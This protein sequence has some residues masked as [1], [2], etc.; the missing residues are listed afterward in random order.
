[1]NET[2][3]KILRE[4]LIFIHKNEGNRFNGR[5]LSSLEEE[6]LRKHVGGS[7]FLFYII[8]LT[9]GAFIGFYS[10]SHVLAKRYT[11]AF[12]TVSADFQ[13]SYR[14]LQQNYADTLAKIE[15]QLDEAKR[16]GFKCDD[17]NSFMKKKL[18]TITKTDQNFDSIN[19][20]YLQTL[21]EKND[22]DEQLDVAI[23]DLKFNEDQVSH[24]NR[25]CKESGNSPH[26]R[27]TDQHLEMRLNDQ[28]HQ[29]NILKEK[30]I[31]HDNLLESTKEAMSLSSLRRL[32]QRYG[33]GPHQV[34]VEVVHLHGGSKIAG[35]FTV[36]L[37]PNEMMPYTVLTFLDMV[38]SGIYEGFSFYYSAD[39]VLMVG[40]KNSDP[41][42]EKAIQS[43]IKEMSYLPALVYQEHN[44]DYPHKKMTLGFTATQ[45]GPSFYISKIDNTELH[46]RQKDT[47]EFGFPI[48]E[49]EPCFG[50][51][52]KD[53][54]MVLKIDSLTPSKNHPMENLVEIERI[55]ILTQQQ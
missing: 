36:E 50:K 31:N 3:S 22:V 12:D 7:S 43:M 16:L 10:S 25:I 40:D 48:K 34:L 38:T 1:M 44:P 55:T 20:S 54:N 30:D 47:G 21:K 46:G 2:E 18:K 49:G 37:A 4:N 41:N 35:S 24:L 23:R 32:N 53:V 28:S 17:E 27:N 29:I 45:L 14:D 15:K 5:D 33:K 42:K 11:S 19:K 52:I 9:A 6:S 26:P 13:K 8:F 51:V 39:H